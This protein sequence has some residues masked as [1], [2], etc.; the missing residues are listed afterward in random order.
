VVEQAVEVVQTAGVAVEMA[1][2]VKV[3]E[4][5]AVV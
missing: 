5:A 3:V 4:V 1:K 2:R